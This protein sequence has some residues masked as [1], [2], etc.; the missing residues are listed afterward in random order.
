MVLNGPPFLNLFIMN[1]LK[2]ISKNMKIKKHD[3]AILNKMIKQNPNLK[4]L[5]SRFDLQLINI[6]K[7]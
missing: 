2:I 7:S 3:K 5:I 1:K 4:N 6:E